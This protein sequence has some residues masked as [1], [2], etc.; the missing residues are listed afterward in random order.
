MPE[1]DGDMSEENA[2]RDETGED[3]DGLDTPFADRLDDALDGFWGGEST[4]LR[5]VLGDEGRQLAG[6]LR[7]ARR[8]TP[9][10]GDRLGRYRLERLLGHGGMGIV[11]EATQEHPERRVA[12]KVLRA[13][14]LS[15]AYHRKAFLREVEMLVRVKHPYVA[16]VYEADVEDGIDFFVMELVE[17]E[18][19][20]E[21]VAARPDLAIEEKVALFEKILDGVRHAH[22]RG[23]IHRDLKPQNVMVDAGGD[24]KILDFGLARVVGAEITLTSARVE[25]Q[26]PVGTLS[27]MSPEQAECDLDQ[28][29]THSDVYAL[30]VML[31]ELLAGKRPYEVKGSTASE[32]LATIST[33]VPSRLRSVGADVPTDLEAITL[34]ALAKRP[35]E[36]Y[37]S[38]GAMLRDVVAYQEGNPI[39]A[40]RASF[41]YL[42]WLRAR[43]HRRSLAAAALGAVGAAVIAFVVRWSLQW[44][45]ASEMPF[46]LRDQLLLER[47][48]AESDRLWPP[49]PDRIGALEAL[50]VAGRD[51]ATTLP[52]HEATLIELRA[53]GAEADGVWSFA[54]V[55]DEWWHGALADWIPRLRRFEDEVVEGRG[56]ASIEARLEYARAVERRSFGEHEA[57]WSKAIE[58]IVTNRTYRGLRIVPQLEL[59]PIRVPVWRSS[60]ILA[61]ARSRG[62]TRSRARSCSNP[63]WASCSSFCPAGASRWGPRKRF[64]RARATTRPRCSKSSRCTKSRSS[65]SSSRSTS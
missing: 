31:Y 65:R 52:T 10:A 63:R 25:Q 9:V 61:P 2:K 55:H 39:A 21:Y 57:E 18:R 64:P 45:E 34:K 5:G 6:E 22:Q 13:D 24:P 47:H 60:P 46:E 42:L 30:G 32:A 17:G 49:Y 59:V 23:I 36:R 50:R 12:V 16:G 19:L 28:V 33:R 58:R 20:D 40:R 15:D 53:R 11:F 41:G 51:L 29:G 37:E 8:A 38:A 27:Y 56:T 3:R 1:H 44:V 62:G 4:G 54:S 43:K 7:R 48:R 26:S 35:T 14:A